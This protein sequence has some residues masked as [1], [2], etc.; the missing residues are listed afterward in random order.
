MENHISELLYHHDCVIVTDFGGFVANYRPSF[1]HP[2]HHTITPPSKKLA[3]NSSLIANDGLLAH[4]VSKQQ[5]INYSEACSMIKV[6]RDHCLEV[7]NKGGKLNLDKIGV[8]YLDNEKNIQFTA[9]NSINY[10]RDSFGLGT[11]HTPVIKT[12]S[13]PLAIT[14]A[15]KTDSR[16]SWWRLLEIAPLAAALAF[17]LINS[18]VAEQNI[19]QSQSLNSFNPIDTF[20]Q[21]IV[22]TIGDKHTNHTVSTPVQP[23]ETPK[24]APVE[25]SEVKTA[26]VTQPEEKTTVQVTAMSNNNSYTPR[27]YI[28]A[29]CFKIAD[30]AENFKNE[31]IAKGYDAEII[32]TYKGLQ[33]V[34]CSAAGNLSDADVALQNV[35][36]SLEPGAW[37]MKK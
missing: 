25:T 36:Q 9:D 22:A 17:L 35:K 6:F 10:L 31:L 32:G 34:S 19:N 15:F 2:S 20:R 8:L 13:D 14:R 7:L 33:V 18:Q 21:R 11:L 1:I 23:A 30:N 16:K 3:F 4:H 24:A 26:P 12:E 28:V 5:G 37:I 29:G 27:F